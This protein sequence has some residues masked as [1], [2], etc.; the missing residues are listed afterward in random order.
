MHPVGQLQPNAWGFC[1]MHGLCYEA[2]RDGLRPYGPEEVVDPIG[3][4]G[5]KTGARG[6][7]WGRGCGYQGLSGC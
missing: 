2:L 7:A 4:L 6:G 3:P 1:D 5:G